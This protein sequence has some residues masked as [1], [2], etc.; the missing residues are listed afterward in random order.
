MNLTLEM[1]VAAR[2]K[3]DEQEVPGPFYA[4]LP[5]M[6]KPM[7]VDSPQFKKWWDENVEPERLGDDNG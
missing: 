7:R 1:L 6:K 5:G 2:R 3:L 4:W